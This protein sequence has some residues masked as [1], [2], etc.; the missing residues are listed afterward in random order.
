[1]IEE[2]LQEEINDEIDMQ[3]MLEMSGLLQ[4]AMAKAVNLHKVRAACTTSGC[5]T[6]GRGSKHRGTKGQDNWLSQ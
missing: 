5:A 6:K 4:V 3:T 1:M 2:L